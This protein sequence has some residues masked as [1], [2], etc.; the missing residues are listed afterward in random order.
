MDHGETS[1]F[2]ISAQVK[3]IQS[4]VVNSHCP[5]SQTHPAV[6]LLTPPL[7]T[8]NGRIAP[9]VRLPLTNE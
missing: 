7:W 5:S 9:R 1:S 2:D 6:D 3:I 8:E 4:S